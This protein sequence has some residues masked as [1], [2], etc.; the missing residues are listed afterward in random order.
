MFVTQIM[1][2]D[3]YTAHPWDKLSRV[4][5][6][7]RE[8]NI[9]FVPVVTDG[10]VVGVLTDRDLLMRGRQVGPEPK[11]RRVADVMTKAVVACHDNDE[12]PAVLERMANAHVRRLPVLTHARQARLVGVVSID[13]LACLVEDCNLVHRILRTQP[14]AVSSVEPAPIPEGTVLH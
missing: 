12:L 4:Q 11:R 7:M 2:R 9:G 8:H 6:V 10:V 5:R 1:K 14:A 13:D 3:V